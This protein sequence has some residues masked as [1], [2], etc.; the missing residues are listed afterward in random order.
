[1]PGLSIKKIRKYPIQL[2][3]QQALIDPTITTNA[4]VCDDEVNVS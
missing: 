1:M 3:Q 2:P 4:T